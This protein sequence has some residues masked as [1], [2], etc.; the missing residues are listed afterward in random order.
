MKFWRTATMLAIFVAAMMAAFALHPSG[1][2]AAPRP[3]PS[4]SE[5][6]TA[7]PTPYMPLEEIP[8][9]SWDVIEQSVSQITYSRMTL[10]EDGDNV[11]GT[12]YADNKK[13]YALDGTREGA[14]LSLEIKASSAPDAAVIGKMEADI[15]GIADM[16]GSITIG[17]TEVAFQ[18]AQHGRVPAPVDNNDD[19]TPAPDATF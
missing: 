15:D 13:V 4:P 11:S 17:S 2:A 8:N 16:I 7:Q 1:S 14:H 5:S 6:P 3:K 9:G 12:W 18:G 19:T 10:K